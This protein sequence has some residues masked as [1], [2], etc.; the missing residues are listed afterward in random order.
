M[1]SPFRTMLVLAPDRVLDC[2]GPAGNVLGSDQLGSNC[3]PEVSLPKVFGDKQRRCAARLREQD[4]EGNSLGRFG[5][6]YRFRLGQ[7]RKSTVSQGKILLI[8]N[9]H[10]SSSPL[11]LCIS[12]CEP[13]D[14]AVT[15]G[16]MQHSGNHFEPRVPCEMGMKHTT[17]GEVVNQ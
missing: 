7:N 14:V 4:C 1:C 10:G 16:K 12:P 13:A 15:Q 9:R 11:F 5:S 17:F 3:R 6:A 2:A 8:R